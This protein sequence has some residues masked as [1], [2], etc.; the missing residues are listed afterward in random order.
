[1]GDAL[2]RLAAR[3]YASARPGD[4]DEQFSA[5][6]DA[7]LA[8]LSAD[9]VRRGMSPHDALRAARLR[10]GNPGSLAQS[11]RAMRGLPWFD[12]FIQD[13]RWALR[14]IAR[15]RWFSAAA[16]VALALGIGTNATGFTIVH[17]A[18][19]RG[20]PY[21]EADRLLMLAWQPREGRR[22]GVSYSELRDWREQASTFEGLGAF[23]TN[24]MNVSD[25][26]ALPERLPAARITANTFALLRQSPIVG[27]G[28]DANDERKA[29]EPVA[30]VSERVWRERFAGNPEIVGHV[31]RL[32]GRP[33]TIVGVMPDAMRFPENASLWTPLVP[34]DD[35]EQRAA[36]ILTIFGRLGRDASRR[37]AETEMNGI[38][39]RLATA[40]APAY[41]GFVG[42]RVE[43]VTERFVGGRARTMF[44]VTMGAVGFVL[45]IAC[46]NVANLL[47]ARSMVR[48]R[49][50]ALRLALGATRARVIRQLLVESL[51]LALCGGVLGLLLAHEGVRLFDASVQDP[52]KPFW[53]VFAID[54]R[55]VGYVVAICVATAL[56]FG[57]VPALHVSRSN[58]SVLVKDGGRGL[59]GHARTRWFSAAM[60]VSELALTIV[61][62]AGAGLMIRSFLNLESA[63][64]STRAQDLLA[65]RLDLPS[66]RYGSAD[67]RRAFYS[68]LETRLRA[69]PGISGIALTTAVPPFN[70]EER[71][72]EI[73]GRPR[74]ADARRPFV[75]VVTIDASFFDTLGRPL[76]RGRGFS[77]LAAGDPPVVVINE[78]LATLHFPGTDPIG[79]R[80]QLVRTSRASGRVDDTGWRTIVGI[81]PP[82]R[83]SAPQD[84]DTD[85]VVYLPSI[86][87]PPASASIILR[88]ALPPPAVMAPAR[89]AVQAIDPDQPVFALQTVDELRESRRW[90]YRTFGAAFSVFAAIGLL[91]S[92]LGLYAVMARSVTQRT[93][94]IG[95]RMAVGAQPREVA[96]MILR[97]G[98]RQ[99]GLGVAIGIAGALALNQV[100]QRMLVQVT[101]ADPLTFVATI[102]I[103]AAVSFAACFVPARRAW[104]VNPVEA[105]RAE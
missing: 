59:A 66:S 96:W 91:L 70:D 9:N 75:S 71:I 44:L 24:D 98:I 92:S 23:V 11:H 32:D 52:G 60:V 21:E 47:L 55:V 62:L 37:T 33:A 25:D 73:D 49:D 87:E 5:E 69:I 102:A 35:E 15:D 86:Q 89:T 7:H 67:A 99:V 93:Q 101:A 97:Q 88:S 100:L 90:G 79:Q 1:M 56:M 43:T 80:V 3:F 31:I 38:A 28:F 61:L 8:M 2:R 104:R 53:I 50:A 16:I 30:I 85:P 65:M 6:L 4:A 76:S 34:S 40:Y 10:L 95:V 17:A 78:R 64:G 18:F 84:G 72:L 19:L 13:T 26:R 48:A 82:I 94:E 77:Q 81:S 46:A 68:Q 103:L 74:A 83:H 41:E 51:M 42:V 57:L 27:R 12:A 45:L 20:L 39:Q 22:A 54:Y 105:L 63:D 29:A 36:R 58:V 14:S